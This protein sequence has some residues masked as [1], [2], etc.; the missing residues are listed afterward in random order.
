MDN[1]VRSQHGTKC[2]ICSIEGKGGEFAT[3]GCCCPL[4]CPS[5]HLEELHVKDQC[6]VGRDGA[7]D[8][9]G[10]VAHVGGDGQLGALPNRHLAQALVPPLDHLRDMFDIKRLNCQSVTYS[11]LPCQY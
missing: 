7:R 10:A 9:L 1:I 4:R 11:P 8:A 2:Q 5:V 6:R 3:K